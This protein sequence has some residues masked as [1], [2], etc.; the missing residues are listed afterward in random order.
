VA[1]HV[2]SS[3]SKPVKKDVSKSHINLKNI[4]QQIPITILLL[5]LADCP[6]QMKLF[7]P[8]LEKLLWLWLM[9]SHNVM[10]CPGGLKYMH[11]LSFR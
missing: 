2:I 9:G 6:I 11:L 5:F 10:G 1:Y 4:I 3:N 8:G 7:L